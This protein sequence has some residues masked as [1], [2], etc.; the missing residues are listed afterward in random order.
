ML[1]PDA[2]G[3]IRPDYVTGPL[4]AERFEQVAAA[5]PDRP[6]LVYEGAVLSYGE[7]CWGISSAMKACCCHPWLTL[8]F[9]LGNNCIK[10]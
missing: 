8:A 1:H 10:R 2:V 3:E 9:A 6:C 4:T 7:V 5:Q